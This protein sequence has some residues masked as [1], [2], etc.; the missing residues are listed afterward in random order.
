MKKLYLILTL[1]GFLLPT[2]FV[3]QESVETGN[4]LLYAD[5]LHTIRSMFANRISTIFSID[6]LFAVIV[7]F[8]WTFNKSKNGKRSKLWLVWGV[9]LLFGFASGLPLYLYLAESAPTASST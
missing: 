4:Y 8:I 2:F 3:I 9:T 5:P 7:F 6:L 1:I